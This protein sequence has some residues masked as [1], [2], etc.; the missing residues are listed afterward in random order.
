MFVGHFDRDPSKTTIQ[1]AIDALEVFNKQSAERW[2][3]HPANV[4][5][6]SEYDA[7][8]LQNAGSFGLA[9]RQA[10]YVA[11]GTFYVGWEDPAMGPK[12]DPF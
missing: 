9:I 5:L 3:N 6:C 2:N 1:K 8:A 10:G 4:L 12:N 11:T 7:I